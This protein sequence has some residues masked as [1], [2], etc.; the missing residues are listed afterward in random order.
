MR[1]A[2][3]WSSGGDAVAAVD[4]V[5]AKTDAGYAIIDDDKVRIAV[6]VSYYDQYGNPGAAGDTLQLSRS[7]TPSE[8]TDADDSMPTVVQS[9]VRVRSNGTA[10]FS[11]NNE[12]HRRR[13]DRG[14]VDVRCSHVDSHQHDAA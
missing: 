9:G 12:C 13:G 11:A 1:P 14:V 5:I 7:A 6:T 10:R 2:P 8:A 4:K 3:L